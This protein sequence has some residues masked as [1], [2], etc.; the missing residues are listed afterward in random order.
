M[1]T[2]PAI[3]PGRWDSQSLARAQELATFNRSRVYRLYTETVA[4]VDLRPIIGRYF[5]GFTV[6]QA[7]G[8]W[9]GQTEPATV[10][11]I[12]GKASDLQSVVYLAGD[13]R[14]VNRQ[15]CVLLTWHDAAMLTITEDSIR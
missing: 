1:K 15:S 12:V 3:G 11:E 10:I 8:V 2:L 5:E 14:V 7:S 6:Y 9:Q 4:D 13:I